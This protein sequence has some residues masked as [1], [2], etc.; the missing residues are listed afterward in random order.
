MNKNSIFFLRHCKT[1]Y[2]S[3]KIITG[4]SNVRI[5]DFFI[6]NNGLDFSN[7]MLNIISSPSTRCIETVNRF[8]IKTNCNYNLVTDKRLLERNMGDWQGVS[9]DTVMTQ[10]PSLFSNNT[11]IPLYTPP[12]GESYLVFKSRI[13]NFVAEV[14]KKSG[15]FLICSHNQTL[16]MLYCMLLSLEIPNNWPD[17]NFKNGTVI[18]II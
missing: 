12:N 11:F 18:R 10:N 1:L 9:K 3:E 4:Q 7:S 5:V 16:K 17:W 13:Q 6:D 14:Q 2:N 15:T 8:V